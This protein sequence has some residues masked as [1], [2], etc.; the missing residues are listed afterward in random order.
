MQHVIE[1][2]Y[3]EILTARQSF[4]LFEVVSVLSTHTKEIYHRQYAN[5]K[6]TE[7]QSITDIVKKSP[8]LKDR[9]VENL[10]TVITKIVPLLF[11]LHS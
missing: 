2:A 1:Y 6:D 11:L 5:V 9:I 7:A 4:L 8:I 10:F 3:E